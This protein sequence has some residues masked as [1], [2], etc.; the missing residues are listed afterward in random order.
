MD[1]IILEVQSMKKYFPIKKGFFKRT[2][3]QVKAVDDVSFYI[4]EGETFGLVG[5]SGCGKSTLGKS[6]LRAIE[7]TEGLVKFKNRH[8]ETVNVMDLDYKK[9]R[10][11]RRDM[12]LIFQDPYSSLNPRMTVLNIIGEPLICNKLAKG[13]ELREKVKHLMEIVGLNSRHLE[14]Y[15]HAFSGGQRQRIGIARALATNPKFLV[16]DEAVSAL[17][18]SI[19]AQIINLLEDLQK[20]LN[21][22]YLFISH[23][24]GVIQH[25]SDRVGV[26]Y[27]GKMVETAT[28]EE[29]FTNPKH[30]YTE[31]LL[32]AKPM[33]NPR[34]KKERIILKG[35]VA[36]PANPPSGCYFHPRCPY[37]QEICK[38]QAPT[39]N[40]VSPGHQVACHFAGELD[41]KGSVA[42]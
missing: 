33:P 28:T 8:N 16:C 35:E 3:G 34:L 30:P 15:P 19:Q 40:E 17:D 9:L 27:V 42:I 25:I 32:S 21:L 10:D 7:P 13:D 39:F 36:N 38:L 5:E 20:S 22:S 14:R 1:D 29:L 37:A 24:L 2:V 26:M 31:A 41:L 18:V 4:K 11:I 23:D 6:L 12:Q